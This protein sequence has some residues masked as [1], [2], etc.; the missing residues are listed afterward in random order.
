MDTYNIPVNVQVSLNK[1][2]KNENKAEFSNTNLHELVEQSLQRVAVGVDVFGQ[3]LEPA[4]DERL[5]ADV[6][7]LQ[8]HHAAAADRGRGGDCEVGHLKH[9]RH[10]LQQ[11]NIVLN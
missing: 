10:T 2:I 4:L 11:A 8:V 7:R 1:T 3:L 5:E 6:A 9:H